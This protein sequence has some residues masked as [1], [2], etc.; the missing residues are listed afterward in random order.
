MLVGVG[1]GIAPLRAILMLLKLQQEAG[2]DFPY[3][4]EVVL[5]FG[6]RHSATVRPGTPGAFT[7]PKRVA[8]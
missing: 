7:F 3:K 6:C 1:T 4:R 8:Q 2:S 5:Y